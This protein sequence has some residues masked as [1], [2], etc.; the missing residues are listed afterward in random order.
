MSNIAF[1]EN[2]LKKLKIRLFISNVGD[3][4]VIEKMK[5]NKSKN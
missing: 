5:K 3:R 4:Y 2:F 1:S